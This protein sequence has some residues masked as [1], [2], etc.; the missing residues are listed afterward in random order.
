MGDP[1]LSGVSRRTLIRVG[2]VGL[3]GALLGAGLALPASADPSAPTAHGA[4]G[5]P[6]GD[7]RVAG[8]A[9]GTT[10]AGAAPAATPMTSYNGWTVGT[11]GSSIGIAPYAVPGTSLT[12]QLRSGDVGTVLSYFAGRFHTEVEKLQP[13]Q[14]GGYEYR[15]N[16]NNPTVWSNHASG[17]AID[18]NWELHPNTKAG[19][20]SPAQLAALRRILEYTGKVVYW[21]GD[22]SRTKDEMHFEINVGPGSAALAELVAKIR[23]DARGTVVSLRAQINDRLVT[24]ENRGADPLIANRTAAGP[25]EKFD[26]LLLGSGRVALR[27]HANGRFVCAESRGT[28]PLIANRTTVGPWETFVLVRNSDGTVSLRAVINGR[29]VTAESHG[30]AAL[31]A[32]RTAIGPWERFAPIGF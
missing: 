12:L 16:V 11:P 7:P 17:T 6:A 26:M 15:R 5:A 8:R 21:G 24:A 19:T 20:F 4:D 18:L 9:T 14:C 1:R 30:R 29:Y 23:S 32:N 10:T 22:Y 31:I 25:W 27:A 28:E 3:G 2:G 13:W